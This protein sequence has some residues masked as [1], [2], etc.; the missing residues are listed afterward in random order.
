MN[1]NEYGACQENFPNIW[2]RYASSATLWDFVKLEN[3]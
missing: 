2:S 1:A 3:L